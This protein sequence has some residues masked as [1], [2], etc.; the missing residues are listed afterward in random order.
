VAGAGAVRLCAAWAAT[1]VVAALFVACAGRTEVSPGP[2]ELWLERLGTLVCDGLAGCCAST[3]HA[4]NQQ[5]CRSE[6][7]RYLP[8]GLKAFVPT[9]TAVFDPEQA[10]LCLAAYRAVLEVCSDSKLMIEADH[11]CHGVFRGTVPHGGVCTWSGDCAEGPWDTAGCL[12]FSGASVATCVG[13]GPRIPG[14]GA[15]GEPCAGNCTRPEAPLPNCAMRDDAPPELRGC[16]REDGLYCDGVCKALPGPDDACSDTFWCQGDF[17]C[18][19]ESVC[20]PFAGEGPCDGEWVC[21]QRCTVFECVPSIPLG[22][23]CAPTEYCQSGY[24]TVAGRC[25]L[26]NIADAERCSGGNSLW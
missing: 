5:I 4:F 3:G 6:P 14:A 23:R 2:A 26:W 21:S 1:G 8:V 19:P 13:T 17:Y 7:A 9:D 16:Y 18:G 22:D 20:I 12:R 10:E 25:E 11:V 24:C 15:L